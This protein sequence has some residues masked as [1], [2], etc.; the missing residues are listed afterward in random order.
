[1]APRATPLFRT[2]SQAR[3]FFIDRI[4]QQARHDGVALSDDEREMLRWSE[5]EPESVGA[6]ALAERLAAV[7]PED[8]YGQKIAGLIAPA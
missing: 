8:Q 5:V 2:P 4:V 1:M 6:P 7:I 3:Q